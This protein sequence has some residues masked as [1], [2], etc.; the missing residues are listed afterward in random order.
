MHPVLL[1]QQTVPSV[2]GASH[3]HANGQEQAE[4]VLS[5]SMRSELALQECLTPFLTCASTW[6]TLTAARPSN[7][8]LGAGSYLA[9]SR[10]GRI[11]K[12]VLAAYKRDWRWR[13]MLRIRP[14][15]NFWHYRTSSRQF[16]LPAELPPGGRYITSSPVIWATEKNCSIIWSHNFTLPFLVQY[17]ITSSFKS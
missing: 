9:C 16:R 5:G 10:H 3:I 17:L 15:W 14:K 11:Q 13:A 6:S 8:T 12:N 7:N 2:G 4:K 1:T